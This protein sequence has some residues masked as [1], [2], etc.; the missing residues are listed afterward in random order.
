MNTLCQIQTQYYENYGT[1]ESPHWKEKGGQVFT[2]YVDS[3][4]FLYMEKECVE[5][6]K[7]LIKEHCNDH[8]K[9]EYVFHELI[10]SKPIELKGFDEKFEK[11]C[12][13]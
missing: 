11:V 6:I 13:F 8:Q 2:M 9:F 12:S 1:S 5:A 7:L 10:F 3:S 4:D